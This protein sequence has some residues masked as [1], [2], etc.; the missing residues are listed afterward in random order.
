MNREVAFKNIA[1]FCGLLLIIGLF[2]TFNEPNKEHL[3]QLIYHS[4][5]MTTCTF[6]YLCYKREIIFIGLIFYLVSFNIKLLTNPI[7]PIIDINFL[8]SHLSL[9]GLGIQAI[10]VVCI[11]IGFSSIFEIKFFPEKFLP[12]WM[13]TFLIILFFTGLIQIA[14]RCI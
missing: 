13:P 7:L 1:I 11:I 2:V 14:A 12:D 9:I 5:G 8:P 3:F 4:I 6:V 10:S